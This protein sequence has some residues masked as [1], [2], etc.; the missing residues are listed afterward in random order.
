[1]GTPLAAG[2]PFVLLDAKVVTIASG[3]GALERN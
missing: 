3:L 2:A 1:M